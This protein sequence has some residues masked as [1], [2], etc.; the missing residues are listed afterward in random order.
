MRTEVRRGRKFV[1]Y[2]DDSLPAGTFVQEI[3]VADVSYQDENS[4]WRPIDENWETDGQDGFSFRAQRMNHKVR[5]D[6]IL[7]RSVLCGSSVGHGKRSRLARLF[8]NFRQS[9]AKQNFRPDN[10]HQQRQF[11]A[12]MFLQVNYHRCI[13]RTC[14]RV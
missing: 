5:F 10:L 7:S 14:A 8:P 9:V 6:S 3:G 13:L 4:V 11:P 1:E 12:R 2:T